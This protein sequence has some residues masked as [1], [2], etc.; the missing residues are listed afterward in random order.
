MIESPVAV[1]HNGNG[2][3]TGVYQSLDAI[4]KAIRNAFEK[5]DPT[6]R[7]FREKVYR[8]IYAALEKALQANTNLDDATKARRREA[9]SATISRVE[10]EFLPAVPAVDEEFPYLEPEVPVAEPQDQMAYSPDPV[11]EP[12]IEPTDRRVHEPKRVDPDEWDR[13]ERSAKRPA[14]KGRSAKTG[15][16]GKGRR[17]GLLLPALIGSVALV[18]LIG[19]WWALDGGSSTTPIASTPPQIADDDTPALPEQPQREIGGADDLSDWIVVFSP[20]DPTTV[21]AP[22]DSRADVMA[23]DGNQ[24]IRISSGASGGPVLFDVGQGVLERVSGRRAV[25]AIIAKSSE[26]EE[27]QIAIDCS[28]A[29]LGDCGRKRFAVGAARQ[30]LLFEMDMDSAQPGS[31]GTIAINP[32]IA[33]AGNG[34]DIFEIRVSP[35]Q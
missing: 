21:T 16:D 3:L 33:G 17:K 27:T 20:S 13:A 15:V 4:E 12:R 14:S 26:A 1:N 5:G 35:A 32:G 28:L 19:V 24:F 6:Q 29:E 31:G 10:S 8:S 22:G 30:E 23:A 9:L 34:V 25:F 11:F 18:A 2:H 7:D